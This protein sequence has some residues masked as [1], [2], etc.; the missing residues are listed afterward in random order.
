M[1]W[2]NKY[3]MTPYY[4]M[5]CSELVEKVQ[6]EEFNRFYKFPQ[7]N[8]NIF[9]ESK[10][11]K[12]EFLNYV[13]DE[14]T[15]N[16]EEGDLVLMNATHEMAHVG[17]LCIINHKL[18]VLHSYKQAGCVCLHKLAELKTQGLYLKGIYK[19]RKLDTTKTL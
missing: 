7:S 1:H 18:F 11:I 3:T 5:N 10:R 13:I 2:S 19:W 16:I 12:K 17:V 15:K 6:A 4:K 14:K 9:T 8:G